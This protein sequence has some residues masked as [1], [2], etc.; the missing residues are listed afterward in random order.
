[1]ADPDL[2]VSIVTYK[3]PELL[4]GCLA[5]LEAERATWG[6]ALAVVVSDNGSGDASP[7]LVTEG[8]PWVRLIQHSRNLGFG[9]AHN[10]A[11]RGA[12][13]RY[14]LV[15]NSDTVVQ[16]GSLRRLVDFLEATP[17][18][19]IVGPRLRYP[20][21][22]IQPSRRRFPTLA[23][24]LLESTQLQRFWPGN[25]VRRRYLMA[26]SPE[27]RT[28]D[29]DWLVGAALC[30]RTRAARDLGLFDERYFLYSEE[31]DWCRR[32]R[33]AGW[34]VVYLP[35]AEVV[36]VEGGTSRRDLLARDLQFHQSRRG[37]MARWHGEPAGAALQTYVLVEYLA[38]GLEESVK[39]AL[40]SRQAERRA[41]LRVI[42]GYLR[43]SLRR[44]NS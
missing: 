1:M 28:Q 18:V 22:S 16:P 27:A 6:E 35:S 37:Y 43:H 44:R 15:L 32:F 33:A 41:R 29:V 8:F 5:A 34:R 20:N 13:A 10:L 42:A 23:T 40:G 17:D 9:A 2:L 26:D 30:V 11:L 25:P 4:Q 39:L 3:T 38:R 12:R 24:Y 31:V 19:G 14:L 21:G 7:K 36:H